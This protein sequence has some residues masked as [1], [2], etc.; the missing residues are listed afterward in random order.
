MR[1]RICDGL[2]CN[3]AHEERS[4][5]GDE[6]SRLGWVDYR[7]VIELPI[8]RPPPPKPLP[9]DP[10]QVEG[11]IEIDGK[12]CK[13][14][15]RKPDAI[16]EREALADEALDAQEASW[17]PRPVY[18][19]IEAHLCPKCAPKVNLKNIIVEA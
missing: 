7:Y 13:F 4:T 19:T 2:G 10:D 18:R 15:I 1:I 6:E 5:Y 8:D 17:K 3:A 9:P 11:E 14:L 12:T 16:K